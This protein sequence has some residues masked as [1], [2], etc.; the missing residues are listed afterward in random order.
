MTFDVKV[1]SKK[2]KSFQ[3]VNI[4]VSEFKSLLSKQITMTVKWRET[5]L[6]MES[7]G[8]KNIFEIGPGNVLSGLVKRITKNI[9]CFS[10]QN[11]EDMDNLE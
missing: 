6:F 3:F 7:K 10:I 5:I 8:V 9:E 1:V 2:F 4:F 11:P